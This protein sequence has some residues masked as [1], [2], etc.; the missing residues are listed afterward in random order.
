MQAGVGANNGIA[1]QRTSQCS[2]EVRN[3]SELGALYSRF[4]QIGGGSPEPPGPTRDFLLRPGTRA[5]FADL[6]DLRYDTF[7]EP[8]DAIDKT[9]SGRARHTQN[10]LACVDAHDAVGGQLQLKPYRSRETKLAAKHQHQIRQ[11]EKLIDRID[12]SP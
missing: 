5:V 6:G 4:R 7:K 9:Q 3:P 10:V 2:K 1:R 12:V 11:S 8:L